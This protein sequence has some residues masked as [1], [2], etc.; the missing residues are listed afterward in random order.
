MSAAPAYTIS[1]KLYDLSGKKLKHQEIV[2]DTE[3][4]L[5]QAIQAYMDTV[6]EASAATAPWGT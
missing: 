4:T 2:L 5:E 6:D 1:V 3:L